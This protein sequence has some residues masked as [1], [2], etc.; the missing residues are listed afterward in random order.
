MGTT[1]TNIMAKLV[2]LICRMPAILREEDYE[3]WLDPEMHK[4]ELLQELLRS[5]DAGEMM[6]YPVGTLVNTP[7][8]DERA[9]IEPLAE[10][11]NS[12]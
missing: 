4:A 12:A 11:P 8:R 1:A 9:L 10:G 2:R 5:Y 7:G 3:A 6:A